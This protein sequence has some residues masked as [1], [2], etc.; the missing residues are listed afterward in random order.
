MNIKKIITLLSII[1]YYFCF[2]N[3]AASESDD[4]NSL[5]SYSS[6]IPF[7]TIKSEISNFS[8][9]SQSFCSFFSYNEKIY[10]EIIESIENTELT[11]K[12]MGITRLLDADRKSNLSPSP[13]NF[14]L[15]LKNPVCLNED[16]LR[17]TRA[18]AH[19]EKTIWKTPQ[20][21]NANNF[22]RIANKLDTF[23]SILENTPV[24]K[25]K[26]NDMIN[27]KIKTF[28]KD[29]RLYYSSLLLPKDEIK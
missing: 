10:D 14:H 27:K 12:P 25:L 2:N 11:Y 21:L 17:I 29:K 22:N 19:I 7:N 18:Q 24:E 13:I 26:N 3:L 6:P 20:G 23:F 5:D 4:T 15:K 1:F 16:E 28:F 8:P 9:F